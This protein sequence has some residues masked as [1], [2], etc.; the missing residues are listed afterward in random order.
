MGAPCNPYDPG[1]LDCVGAPQTPGWNPY[2]PDAQVRM[3]VQPT[4][5]HARDVPEPSLGVLTAL[6]L[7]AVL[8]RRRMQ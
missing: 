6:A 5:Q 1:F 3:E 7:Y 8:R 2:V 4:S